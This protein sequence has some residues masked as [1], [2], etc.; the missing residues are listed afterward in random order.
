MA[1]RIVYAARRQ[2]SIHSLLYLLPSA[3]MAVSIGRPGAF[4]CLMVGEGRKEKR[5]SVHP[6]MH[7]LSLAALPILFWKELRGV[8]AFSGGLGRSSILQF[9]W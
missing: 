7:S 3:A 8:R 6:K 9:P 4:S 1:L 2:V 5:I